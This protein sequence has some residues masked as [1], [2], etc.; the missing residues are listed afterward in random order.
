MRKITKKK[1]KNYFS[2]FARAELFNF[3]GSKLCF[4]LIA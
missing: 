1:E 4:K 2:V 3:E